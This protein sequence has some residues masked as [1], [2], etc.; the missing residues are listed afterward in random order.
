[1]ARGWEVRQVLTLDGKL[2]TDRIAGCDLLHIHRQHDESALRVAADARAAGMAVVW[3]NDDD[4]LAVPR[5][6][7]AYRDYG[8][9]SATRTATRMRRMFGLADLVTTP[10]AVLAERFGALGAAGPTV[11]ENYVRDEAVVERRS[12]GPNT[13]VVLGWLGGQE[14]HLDVERLPIRETMERLLDAYPQLRVETIGVGLG[15]KHERY[16]HTRRV[17]F[18]ELPAAIAHFDIGIAPISDLPINRARS[19]VK[20][21]EYAAAGTPWLA[22][23]LDPYHGLGERQGGMLVA[24]DAWHAALEHLIRSERFRRKLAKRATRWGRSQTVS[25]NVGRWEDALTEARALAS[26]RR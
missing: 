4:M 10:S 13:Q 6:T 15:I 11:I 24:A 1:V 20:V 5:G 19:N 26:S 17:R 2:R 3:D 25:R 22:S 21:K 16:G 12:K 18:E 9:V 14:H 23:R 8:G 7:V